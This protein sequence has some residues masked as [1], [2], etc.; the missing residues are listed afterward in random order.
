MKKLRKLKLNQNIQ[1]SI[2]KLTKPNFSKELL[3]SHFMKNNVILSNLFNLILKQTLKISFI[4]Y[5]YF[6]NK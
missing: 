2:F 6:V 3:L 5:F 4:I 1:E